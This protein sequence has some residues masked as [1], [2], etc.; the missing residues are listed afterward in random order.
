MFSTQGQKFTVHAPVL[1]VVGLNC[2]VCPVVYAANTGVNATTYVSS[3]PTSVPYMNVLDCVFFAISLGKG[4][5]KAPVQPTSV[6]AIVSALVAISTLPAVVVV[7][8]TNVAPVP[9]SIQ[10]P[11]KL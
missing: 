7:A 6:Q 1:A 5:T 4:D 3:P 9:T 8:F 2:R 11:P 10:A